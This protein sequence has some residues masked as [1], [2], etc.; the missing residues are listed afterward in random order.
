MCDGT[1]FNVPIKIEDNTQVVKN[2]DMSA[3]ISNAGI[4]EILGSYLKPEEVYN[5][6]WEAPSPFAGIKDGNRATNMKIEKPIPSYLTIK[7][8]IIKIL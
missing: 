1:E 8:E 2:L 7:G 6:Y 5:T 3:N 4:K